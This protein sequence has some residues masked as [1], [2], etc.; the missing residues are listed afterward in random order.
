M[1]ILKDE[2]CCL[3]HCDG[4][5]QVLGQKTVDGRD[6][7]ML[8]CSDCGQEWRSQIHPNDVVYDDDELTLDVWTKDHGIRAA[9]YYG[10][11]KIEDV[12][13]IGF[14]DEE[15]REA[16]LLIQ[17]AMEIIQEHEETLQ[18]RYR[19]LLLG[20]QCD[21]CGEY[22]DS[23]Y[24]AEHQEGDCRNLTAELFEGVRS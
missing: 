18:Q 9:T 16:Q 15:S 22:F 24:L 19:E 12:A 17:A 6:Y 10:P 1:K 5:A 23:E 11:E 13:T 20:V 8:R 3:L 7:H 4:H 21:M 14:C 2:T